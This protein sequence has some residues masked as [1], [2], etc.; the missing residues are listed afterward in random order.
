[1]GVDRRTFLKAATA[2]AGN[3]GMWTAFYLTRLGADV[4]VVD[5]PELAEGFRLSEEEFA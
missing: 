5:Q 3:F 4:T 1:M 2:G